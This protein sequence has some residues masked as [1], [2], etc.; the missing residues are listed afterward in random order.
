MPTTPSP[1]GTSPPPTHASNSNT[2]TPQSD[3]PMA[4][5]GSRLSQ[6]QQSF[7][8]IGYVSSRSAQ[9]DAHLV[10]AFR[11][12]LREIGRWRATLPWFDRG[13]AVA[14]GYF[15][16]FHTDSAFVPV[17]VAGFMV[18]NSSSVI[19]GTTRLPSV[20]LNFANASCPRS[21]P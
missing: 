13:E 19:G 11:S 8:T 21:E 16:R 4:T 9:S 20:P 5:R 18:R 10:A 17:E 1:T 2:Y 15:T 7:Q 12:G 3:H 14:R 6:A